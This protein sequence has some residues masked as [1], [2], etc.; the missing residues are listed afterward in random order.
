MLMFAV[1]D[2]K[3]M[4]FDSP[5]CV[6][7]EVQASRA[8]EQSVLN[9]QSTISKYPADFAL[10]YLGEY[11]A[12]KGNVITSD[13]P[14]FRHEAMEFVKRLPEDDGNAMSSPKAILPAAGVEE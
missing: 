4:F 1:Y 11:I 9:P 2:K 6:E 7:N 8:F 13:V 5:F 3:A 14:R 10:Y 12:S